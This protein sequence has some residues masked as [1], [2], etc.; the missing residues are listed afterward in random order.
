MTYLAVSYAVQYFPAWASGAL[1]TSP[2]MSSLTIALMALGSTIGLIFGGLLHDNLG[3]RGRF[4]SVL[5]YAV[6][7]S[8]VAISL[9]VAYMLDAR[10]PGVYFAA[11]ASFVYFMY[12]V[13][14]AMGACSA[15]LNYVVFMVYMA[16]K[17][18]KTHAATAATFA[19]FFG[20]AT[21]SVAQLI[22]GHLIHRDMWLEVLI[23]TAAMVCWTALFFILFACSMFYG[24][25]STARDAKAAAAGAAASERVSLSGFT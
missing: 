2:Q 16:E 12:A 3:V 6:L 4:I 9:P 23:V 20:I 18:G 13:G 11:P 22:I 10:N 14:P 1:G 25:P 8:V 24:P 19:D 21:S 5:I 7:M 17:G 15:V